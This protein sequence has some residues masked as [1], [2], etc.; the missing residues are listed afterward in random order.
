MARA[1]CAH[2][3]SAARHWCGRACVQV[4]LVDEQLRKVGL[5]LRLTPYRVLPTATTAGM[6]EMVLNSKPVS[7]VMEEN[8]NDIMSFFRR[9]HPSETGA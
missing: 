8:R 9:H 5:D 3:V 6:M 7:D 2:I 4:R 1:C